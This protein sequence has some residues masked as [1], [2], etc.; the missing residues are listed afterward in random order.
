MNIRHVF[1]TLFTIAALAA[2]CGE[3]KAPESTESIGEVQE[4]T[5][6]ASCVTDANCTGFPPQHCCKVGDD[7]GYE[8]HAECDDE[9]CGGGNC[10]VNC[11]EEGKHCQCDFGFGFG[12]VECNINSQ[13]TGGKTCSSH[14]CVCPSG[15]TDCSGTCKDLQK[16]E[17]NCGTCGHSCSGGQACVAGSCFNC[18][19]GTCVSCT[20]DHDCPFKTKCES[21]VC[22]GHCI[23]HTACSDDQLCVT[24]TC[25]SI[26]ATGATQTDRDTYCR[27]T[28]DNG[29]NPSTWR[30]MSCNIGG[31]N[32][33]VQTKASNTRAP[34]TGCTI[35]PCGNTSTADV[36][37][38]GLTTDTGWG[39]VS[40]CNQ[41]DGGGCMVGTSGPDAITPKA[42]CVWKM[43]PAPAEGSTCSNGDYW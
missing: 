41:W 31:T 14:S 13:C 18:P 12:C 35:T 25:Q 30:M 36:A 20:T 21:D 38:W 6:G 16:D 28:Y 32:R 23:D 19:G 34:G 27:N 4:A 40:Q 15:Q 43:C 11:T 42:T 3:S 10:D 17:S 24:S 2:S 33:C 39:R 1:V 9:A 8:C 7:T 26:T 5:I 22:T 29:T 37:A